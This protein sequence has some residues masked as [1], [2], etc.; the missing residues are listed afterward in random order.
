MRGNYLTAL[1]VLKDSCDLPSVP[2]VSPSSAFPISIPASLH[3]ATDVKRQLTFER[4]FI[5]VLWSHSITSGRRRSKTCSKMSRPIAS[6]GCALLGA[7][8]V[9]IDYLCSPV[10]YE[11][12]EC[13]SQDGA[14]QVPH[15]FPHSLPGYGND[16][17]HDDCVSL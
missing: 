11:S 6:F 3:F 10:F 9:C 8:L 12:G 1:F 7:Y 13:F 16:Q 17:F 4:A 2:S 5:C 15:H 14:V